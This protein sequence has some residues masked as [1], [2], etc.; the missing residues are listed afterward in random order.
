MSRSRVADDWLSAVARITAFP[1]FTARLEGRGE[2]S[3]RLDRPSVRAL[4]SYRSATETG[5]E[6]VQGHRTC[7]GVAESWFKQQSLVWSES[8]LDGFSFDE[9]VFLR[10]HAGPA[11]GVEVLGLEVR[12]VQLLGGLG[13]GRGQRRGRGVFTLALQRAAPTKNLIKAFK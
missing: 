10:L 8:Y 9:L 3:K 1:I 11:A 6:V 5:S 13:E 7:K 12:V 4:R 2:I